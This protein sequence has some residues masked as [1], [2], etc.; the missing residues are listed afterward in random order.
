MAKKAATSKIRR[1]VS[2][3]RSLAATNVVGR[4]PMPPAVDSSRQ[5]ASRLL[6]KRRADD[7]EMVK[8]RLSCMTN[9]TWVQ[10]PRKTAQVEA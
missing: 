2:M 5:A 1:G 3:T 7:M 8:P 6:P 10:G 4:R 9:A